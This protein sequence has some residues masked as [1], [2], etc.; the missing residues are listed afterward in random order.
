MIDQ[1]ISFDK[2]NKKKVRNKD[3]LAYFLNQTP[4]KY[5]KQSLNTPS[6]LWSNLRARGLTLRIE[7]PCV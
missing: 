6:S 1:L 5:T 3:G 4:Y 7:N 2:L